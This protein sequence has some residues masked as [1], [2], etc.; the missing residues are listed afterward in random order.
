MS[1]SNSRP[2]AG[3]LLALVLGALT[4]AAWLGWDR[5]ASFDVVTDSVQYPYVTLQVLGC[6]LTVL[7][8]T[9][10]LAAR[11]RPVLAASGVGLGF[12]LVWT[13]DAASRDDSGLFVVGAFFLAF[14]LAAGTALAAL[15]GVGVRTFLARRRG[16][17]A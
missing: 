15:A 9:A 2:A 5:T 7:V 4:W 16:G 13:V 11:G 1:P 17:R 8:L 12:W 10:V 6:A 3:F 14:G